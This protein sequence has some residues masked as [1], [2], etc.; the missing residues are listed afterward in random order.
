MSFADGTEFA[1]L[2][3]I[4]NGEKYLCPQLE[5]I[6]DQYEKDWILYASDDGSND[7]SMAILKEFQK[8]KGN[9][10]VV[11]RNGPRFGFAKNFLSLL[12]EPQIKARYYALCDQDDI[13]D[14]EKLAAAKISLENYDP[15]LPALYCGRTV[16][17]DEADVPI[18]LSSIPVRPLSFKNA[19]VQNIASGNTMV[20]NKAA[21][22]LLIK[23]GDNI[24]VY[25]HD[26]LIYM[27]VSGVGGKVIYDKLPYIRYRQHNSNQI[28]MNSTLN[29]KMRRLSQLMSGEFSQWNK[30]NIMVLQN[31]YTLLNNENREVLDQFS[32]A[33]HDIGVKA[34]YNLFKSSAYRQRIPQNIALYLAA[35]FGW[36]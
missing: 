5:S 34:I 17:V 26:W 35:F 21:R 18:G 23:C 2:M 10:R 33:A 20:L 3:C 16:F 25:A 8:K 11:I 12:T 13:W 28:G 27:L 19:L 36:L 24:D 14:K 9:Q 1:I 29:N 7:Q 6:N 22:N 31:N 32:N 15:Q 4:Y 30:K